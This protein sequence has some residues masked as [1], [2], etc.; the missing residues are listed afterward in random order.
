MQNLMDS[1]YIKNTG[2]WWKLKIYQEISEFLQQPTE[3]NKNRLMNSLV[4]YQGFY[5]SNSVDNMVKLSSDGQ[6]AKA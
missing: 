2:H 4:T 3:H 6:A 5:I 1:R